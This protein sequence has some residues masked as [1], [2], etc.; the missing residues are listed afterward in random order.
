MKFDIK[1][2]M[3]S[4]KFS[5]AAAALSLVSLVAFLIYG[6]VYPVYADWAAG[7]SLLLAL[8]A[9]AG[10]ALLDSPLTNILPLAG[11][12]LGGLGMNII[13]LNSYTVWADWYGNF[14][15]YGSQGGVAPVILILVLN[16]LAILCGIV[17]CFTRKNKEA[18]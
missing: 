11:V 10:Y 3:L 15:M 13:F 7:L 6:L 17:T 1:H 16:I 2:T 14:N 12:I 8:A 4:A 9:Y 18:A 5:L